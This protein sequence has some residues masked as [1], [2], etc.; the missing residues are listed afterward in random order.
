MVR[1]TDCWSAPLS[2]ELDSSLVAFVIMDASGSTVCEVADDGALVGDGSDEEEAD[3]EASR[4]R[5]EA[6]AAALEA[7]IKAER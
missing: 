2:V 4:E 5:A 6:I 1:L 3:R 7:A